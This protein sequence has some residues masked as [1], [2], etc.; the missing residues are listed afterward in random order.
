MPANAAD[1][2]AGDYKTSCR[3]CKLEDGEASVLACSHCEK[4]C[5]ARIPSRLDTSS[6]TDG[7]TVTN[8]AG[9]LSCKPPPPINAPDVPTGTYLGSCNGCTVTDDLLSCSECTD[10]AGNKHA[11]SLRLDTCDVST[12]S[13]EQGSLSCALRPRELAEERQGSAQPAEPVPEPAVP[14]P[15]TAPTE[16]QPAAAAAHDEL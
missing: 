4:P 3:G 10:G 13:N 1:I 8:S 7:S 2:P 16:P 11:T 14:Q 12:I 9:K 5:G 15:R 6:C